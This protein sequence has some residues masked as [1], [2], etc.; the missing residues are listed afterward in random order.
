MWLNNLKSGIK[1]GV[2][3]ADKGFI[4]RWPNKPKVVFFGPPN[5]FMDEITQRYLFIYLI[6]SDSP[7]I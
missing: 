2:F 5:V 3:G 1:K 6:N 4:K 7:L